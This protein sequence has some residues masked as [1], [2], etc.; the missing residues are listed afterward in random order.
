VRE[1]TGRDWV[2]VINSW[3]VNGELGDPWYATIAKEIY[4]AY[5][6]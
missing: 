2:S 5:E 4:D 3:L 6:E 1:V